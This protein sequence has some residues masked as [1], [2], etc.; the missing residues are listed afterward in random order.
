[1]NGVQIKR[2][3]HLS[4]LFFLSLACVTLLPQASQAA[5]GT[6]SATV[7]NLTSA[8]AGV[9]GA[10]F[11][12]IA[13]NFLGNQIVA[14][15]N[16]GDIF[17][18]TDTGTSW[19]NVTTGTS[20]SG[21]A[22]R[23]VTSSA[24]GE[25]LY[26]AVY[27]GD[28]YKS[29][30]YGSTWGS[31]T[32]TT[33]HNKNWTGVSTS[34]NGQRVFAVASSNYFYYSLNGGSTWTIPSPYP[35]GYSNT[36]WPFTGVST[37]GMGELTLSAS[38]FGSVY[39]TYTSSI[40]AGKVES[41]SLYFN[42]IAVSRDGSRAYSVESTYASD[43]YGFGTFVNYQ[44]N[45]S[46]LQIAATSCY[47]QTC[48]G[49]SAVG[50]NGDGRLTIHGRA[51]NKLFISTDSGYS[52][53]TLTNSPSASWQSIAI[54]NSGSIAYA[55][56]NNGDIYKISLDPSTFSFSVIYNAN[57]GTGCLQQQVQSNISGSIVL[58]SA[59]SKSSNS[60]SYWKV[61]GVN[62]APG[63]TI[64]LTSQAN[65]MAVWIPRFTVTF[66]GNL[67]NSGSAPSPITIDSGT[68]I[69]IPGNSGNLA[70]NNLA[71]DGWNTLSNGLGLNYQA[72]SNYL[73][74]STSTLYAKWST[75][76]STP[77]SLGLVSN[78]QTYKKPVNI[79]ATVQ[80]PGKITFFLN[81]HK[82][83][84]CVAKAIVS[85]FTC[86]IKPNLHGGNIITAKLKPTNSGYVISVSNSVT[87]GALVRGDQR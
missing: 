48:A 20:L 52:F 34:D 49:G 16:S 21:L 58:D 23:T 64:N 5:V 1:M 60:L 3:F 73:V 14:V 50:T 53:S 66:A 57:G 33:G 2:K 15:A 70:K 45:S 30:D 29:S 40:N 85:T 31:V 46:Y 75:G 11:K 82:A 35:A 22:W 17:I 9:S 13:T 18:S 55:A 39:A 4:T 87:L 84:A 77:V 8:I 19:V 10:Q 81:G 78:P 28:I 25:T 59:C 12:D 54:N 27:G 79:L 6:N 51:A 86:A 42:D 68:V 47:L 37:D 41:S 67:Q 43:Q 36:T 26:A 65:A 80:Q 24:S 7:T 38:N 72:G 62:Y 71:F 76:V 32:G 83:S 69:S 63:S 56:V 61:N 74:T 44:E